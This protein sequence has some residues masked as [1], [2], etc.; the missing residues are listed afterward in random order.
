MEIISKP[1]GE[2]VDKLAEK[3]FIKS[4]EIL[5]G[6]KKL[7]EYRNLTWL[8]SLAEASYVV[9]LKNEALKTYS[10]IARELGI[11]E[12]TARSIM[13]ADESRVMEYLKGEMDK[14]PKEHVAGG[15]AKL[16][17]KKLREAG[18]L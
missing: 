1:K 6:L 18:E 11:S 4:I 14:K 16:A 7:V 13:G 12:G 15:I 2:D 8:P 17:Y 9:V 5:G 10:E 3:V